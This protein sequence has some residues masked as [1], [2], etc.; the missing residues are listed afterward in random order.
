[1]A[2][3]SFRRIRAGQWAFI[4]G[5]MIR[6]A[7]FTIL[8]YFRVLRSFRRRKSYRIKFHCIQRKS[9]LHRG[10]YELFMGSVP[11]SISRRVHVCNLKSAA[12]LREHAHEQSIR[13]A[14]LTLARSFMALCWNLN[15]TEFPSVAIHGNC[16]AA[17]LNLCAHICFSFVRTHLGRNDP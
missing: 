5:P 17:Q 10:A 15:K 8:N 13:A 11:K 12:F 9:S 3:S 1:M 4:V 6:K 14:P 2:V 7:S 16:F